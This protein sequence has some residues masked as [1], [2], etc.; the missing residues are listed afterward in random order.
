MNQKNFMFKTIFLALCACLLI[1]WVT[2]P[3]RT[4]DESNLDRATNDGA[5][6]PLKEHPDTCRAVLKGLR[7][8]HYRQIPIDDALSSKV[9]DTYLS[10]LDPS[11][12]LFMASDVNEFEVYRDRLDDL[13]LVGDLGPAFDMYNR[14]IKRATER[15][16][17]LLSSLEDGLSD[18]SF[19]DSETIEIDRKDAA[20]PVDV[21][22]LNDI[23]RSNLKSSALSLKLADKTMDEI[24][25]VL[26]KRYQN[27]INR[28][29]QVNSE[30]AFQVFINS[31]SQQFDPHTTYFSPVLSEEFDISMSQ[32]LD[33]IGALLRMKDEYTTIERLITGGPAEESELLKPADRIVGVGQGPEGE[34]VDV[35]GWRLD[36]VV[37]LI[38]G[39]K[40]TIV[41]L[42]ILPADAP[43]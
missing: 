1:W 18:L 6:V 30:D 21:A 10:A 37:K 8:S 35:V 34:V 14:F 13:T 27:Q 11:R 25:A 28:I 3:A 16:E 32:S 29:Q 15:F 2:P 19:E 12:R 42:K 26:E 5:L 17:Y 24:A 20:W 22:E 31:L 38:R 9:F 43:D 4:M 23:S 33:G 36:E 39:P 41:R 40:K 7:R